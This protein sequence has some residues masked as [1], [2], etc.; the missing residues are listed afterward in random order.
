M[1]ILVVAAHPDDEVLGAGGVI[2]RH[3]D[4]GCSVHILVMAQGVTSR[5]GDPNSSET[6]EKLA[7]LQRSSAA[8]ARALGAASTEN[9]GFPDQEMDTVPFLELA[10]AVSLR[11]EKLRPSIVY[12]HH[13]GDL[14][15]DHRLTAEAAMVACRSMPGCP[16][17]EFY[18]WETLSSTEWSPKDRIFVPRVYFDI[19]KQIDRKVE[20]MR[21]YEHELR[22]YP[23]PR[24]LEGVRILSQARGLEV[25]ARYGE[26][27]DV[28]RLIR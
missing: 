20:A 25:G 22:D 11:V 14:N 3:S 10:K 1:N 9:A 13:H 17:R 2:A 12:T 28:H 4:D 6:R 21:C 16:V 19:E 15:H 24:S 7:S 23:H 8:A 26:A 18:F 27:F 5:G